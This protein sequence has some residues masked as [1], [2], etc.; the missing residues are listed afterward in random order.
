[1]SEMPPGVSVATAGL[2]IESSSFAGWACKVVGGVWAIWDPV[3]LMIV[4]VAACSIVASLASWAASAAGQKQTRGPWRA[5]RA[6]NDLRPALLLRSSVLVQPGL[7][8]RC[9][10]MAQSDLG[11][12]PRGAPDVYLAC[13]V[14][15]TPW[16]ACLKDH[17]VQGK[18][19][20]YVVYGNRM[21]SDFKLALVLARYCA[22]FSFF[23]TFLRY[24]WQS[25]CR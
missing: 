2:A 5:A 21:N 7:H 23:C 19:S 13:L 4:A 6:A 15:S 12:T 16:Q 22:A 8:R 18:A 24:L 14:G 11:S 25:I 3:C 9:P 17:G 20:L 10:V 1:M